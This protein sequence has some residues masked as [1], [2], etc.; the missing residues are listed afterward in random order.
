ME[1]ICYSTIITRP[2]I[3]K[4]AFKLAEHL[5]NPGPVH[6][7]A[8]DQCLR[9]LYSTKFFGIEYSAHEKSSLMIQSNAV[10]KATANVSFANDKNKKN[11]ER[12]TFKLFEDLID[13]TAR[14]QL[15]VTTSTTEAELLSMLHAEKEII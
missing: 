4:T 9:Y 10:M 6:M 15:T 8:A 2:N 7:K 3:A 12:Y 1:S 14:K 13:W 11:D 5:K